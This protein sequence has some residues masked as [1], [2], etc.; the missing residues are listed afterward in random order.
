MK[1]LLFAVLAFSLCLGMTSCKDDGKG[2]EED[3]KEVANDEKASDIKALAE[4]AEKEGMD[5]TVEEWKENFKTI[6]AAMKPMFKD[7]EAYAKRWFDANDEEKKKIA[8]EWDE[9]VDTKY[10]ELLKAGEKF[11]FAAEKSEYGQIV[12]ED[13]DFQEKAMEELEIYPMTQFRSIGE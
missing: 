3:K 6:M 1:K 9:L 7:N 8:D 11:S 12:L 5:W 2:K 10:K 4:K 13:K